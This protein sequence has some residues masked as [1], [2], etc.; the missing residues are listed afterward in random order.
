MSSQENRGVAER[1]RLSVE[2]LRRTVDVSRLGFRTTAEVPP[3]T[4]T[5]GQ[6]RALEALATGLDIPGTGFN[7]FACGSVGP[8][9]NCTILEMVRDRA[10]KRATPTDWCYVHN[11]ERPDEPLA[12]ELPAG[13][14]RELA[15]DMDELVRE[16]R[17]EIPKAFEGEEYD[18]RKSEAMEPMERRRQKLL[19][20]LEQKAQKLEH[21]VQMTPHGVVAIPVMDGETLSAEAFEKL[22]AKKQED[23]R[24]KS[25]Q[26]QDLVNETIREMRRL[27]REGAEEAKRLD[28]QIALFAIEHVVQR[29]IEK[30]REHEKVASHLKR[31]QEHIIENLDA[32][33]DGERK[34]PEVMGVPL[35]MREITEDYRVN[36]LV[37]H[38]R[39]E[40]APVVVE[41][42]PTYTNLFGS[43]EYRSYMGGMVTDYSMIK[44]GAFHR[45]NGGFL[46]LQVL[47]VLR[48]PF[49]WEGLKRTLRTGQATIENMW[50]QYRPVP[51]S[52]L[53]PEAIPVKVKVLLVGSP[54]LHQ[55]LYALDEEFPR[56]FKIKAD[57]DVEMD[58]TEKH[59]EQYAAFVS[60]RCREYGLAPFEREA[61]AKLAEYGSRL[62][63]H[64]ERLS[65]HFLPI[66]DI[67]AEAGHL[68]KTAGAETV[69][70]ADVQGAIDARHRRSR[71]F[72][73]KIQQYIME[74][75]LLIDTEASVVGQV[76]GLAVYDLGDYRF[77]KPSRIT[78]VTSVGRSG[79]VNIERES[80]MSG[81][82]HDKG[83]LILSG[84]LAGRFGQD[85]PLSL[86]A[87]LCFEQS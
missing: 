14:A 44:A 62:A 66:T 3:L 58:F 79:V 31:M 19:R 24:K 11:F 85:K 35:P 51:A 37:D 77:G 83:G 82:I 80:K 5:I 38:S 84:Y 7:V 16:I 1:C 71:M 65:T 2:Q 10:G 70:A 50:E 81:H 72:Q 60:A 15:A 30:Y 13:K 68:A 64:Q 21:A 75:V 23:L 45:A 47:D 56:L 34:V 63:A 27:G 32:F 25:G 18:K 69:R 46:I 59:L 26:I 6:E 42:N 61:V 48:N 54:A 52:T 29:S 74:G 17:R 67:I 20:D 53:R 33:K 39:T 55:L 36:V 28:Q 22:P 9:R 76:N 57:F 49:A 43:L 87:S 40:G 8:G 73:D 86:S 41:R 12:I 78:C 4:G